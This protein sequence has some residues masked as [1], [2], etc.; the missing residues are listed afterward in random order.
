MKRKIPEVI[1][2]EDIIKILNGAKNERDRLAYALGFYECMRVSEV[3]NLLPEHIDKGQKLL[4]IKQAKGKKDR[5]IPIAPEVMRGLKHIPIGVGIR[6]LQ[7]SFGKV[8][9]KVLGRRINFHTLRHCLSEDTEVLTEDGWKRYD[10]LN[11]LSD[12]IYTYNLYEDKI[13]LSNIDRIHKYNHK[14]KMYYI[15]N[16]Y[17]DCL[18]TPEHKVFV[19]IAHIKQKN[20]KKYTKWDGWDLIRMRDLLD[21]PN[22]RLMK[23]KLSGNYDGAISIG[24]NKAALLGWILTDGS[25]CKRDKVV[26][27]GQSWTANK[28]KCEIISNLLKNSG[29]KYSEKKEKVQMNNITKEPYQMI[30]WRIFKEDSKCFFNWINKDRTPKWKL[31][32]LKREELEEIYK[33]MMLGDGSRGVELTTQNKKRIDFFRVLCT[34]INKRAI[35]GYGEKSVLSSGWKYRTHISNRNTCN[36]QDKHIHEVDYDGVVWCP[37]TK[38]KTWI[39]RRNECIFITGNSGATHYLNKKKWDLR[40]V[41]VM[42]GHSKIQV[43]EI[44]THVSPQNLIDKMWG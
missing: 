42:L 11:I 20:K 22:K 12:R 15:Q 29:L 41:Q 38:N 8:T 19:N 37:E 14:G 9:E 1:Q 17:V 43:T 34:L 30:S 7:V 25:I 33:H 27:I 26:R 18:G 40:S 44:Y 6:A 28:C 10:E 16:K 4:R 13:E 21:M 35:L 36:I 32:N 39:A 23:F 24:K 31:L 3:V 5:N 2:E